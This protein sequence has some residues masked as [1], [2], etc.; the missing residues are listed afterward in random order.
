MGYTQAMHVETERDVYT[1]GDKIG[2]GAFSTVY[3]AK[4]S[5]GK[6]ITV[7]AISLTKLNQKKKNQIQMELN[8]LRSIRSGAK[9][10]NILCYLDHYLDKEGKI[11]YIFTPLGGKDLSTIKYAAWSLSTK[12][13]ICLQI[14]YAIKYL[15]DRQVVHC[16]I[17]P[18]NILFDAHTINTTLIDFG[19]ACRLKTPDYHYRGTRTYVAPEFVNNYLLN[20]EEPH[21]VAEIDLCATD[22][23]SL[24]VLFY[25]VFEKHPYKT[26][27][28]DADWDFYM[29]SKI[30]IESANAL[31]KLLNTKLRHRQIKVD[32]N[33]PHIYHSCIKL[34]KN[35]MIWTPE[36]RPKIN[37][38][39][40]ILH[41]LQ[42][43]LVQYSSSAPDMTETT[44]DL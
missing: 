15:H 2:K 7:K 32:V 33:D 1:I 35:M 39:I 5:D 4:R 40:S 14:A 20:K 29:R 22:I 16:D 28:S 23:Y 25:N 38:I 6:T 21:Q 41:G 8:I 26:W 10:N 17:K 12:I 9:R 31:L 13:N 34:C 30:N 42:E 27:I 44:F 19:L 37:R 3:L 11:L 43:N 18:Q 24:G 36:R